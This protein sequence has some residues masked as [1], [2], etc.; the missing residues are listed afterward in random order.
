[1]GPGGIGSKDAKSRCQTLTRELLQ[2]FGGF[3]PVP[4]L[5]DTSGGSEPAGVGGNICRLNLWVLQTKSPVPT[6]FASPAPE[7]AASRSDDRLAFIAK[8]LETCSLQ[9]GMLGN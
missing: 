2:F 9:A 5:L 6:G 1:M 7:Y 4:K 3:R 8:A